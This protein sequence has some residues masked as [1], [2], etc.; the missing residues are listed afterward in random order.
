[1]FFEF[2]TNKKYK[3]LNLHVWLFQKQT[4]ITYMESVFVY[5]NVFWVDN[6]IKLFIAD[7]YHVIKHDIKP[8]YHTCI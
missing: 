8:L 7:I 1:M 6:L 3:K 2:R 5:T 4:L